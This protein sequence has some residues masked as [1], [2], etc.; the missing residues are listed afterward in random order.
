MAS[1]RWVALSTPVPG[2]EEELERWYDAQHI[3]DCLKLDGFTGAQRF[4]IDQPPVG[5]DV[6]RWQVMVIYDIESDD[7][8]ATLAQ[9]PAAIRSGAMPMTKAIEMSTALR[10]LA[11]AAAPKVTA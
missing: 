9:V 11:T 5:T 6:P 10:I 4:R 3:P 1:Y 2:Q 8:D 7:V